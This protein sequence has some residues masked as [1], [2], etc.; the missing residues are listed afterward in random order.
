M[1]RWGSQFGF[2]DYRETERTNLT[3][4]DAL[5]NESVDVVKIDVEGNEL[6]VARGWGG[7][8][9]PPRVPPALILT[10]YIPS[11]IARKSNT[12]DPLEYLRFFVARGYT[13][14][15]DPWQASTEA[16]LADLSRRLVAPGRRA[17]KT[18]ANLVIRAPRA[19]GPGPR[20]R[21]RP[22]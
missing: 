6:E 7:L 21:G 1:N 4:L 15:A 19:R 18:M 16:D 10:E 22:S 11:L 12:S 14:H 8:F 9:A 5:V 3:R 20:V 2:R 13:V 17:S